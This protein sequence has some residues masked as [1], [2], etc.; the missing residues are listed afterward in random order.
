MQT[1][2]PFLQKQATLTRRSTV[3]SI[4]VQLGFPG[5]ADKFPLG[6]L[7]EKLTKIQSD[8]LKHKLVT[9]DLKVPILSIIF[10]FS[11]SIKRIQY[12]KLNLYLE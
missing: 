12:Q 1:L 5:G 11:L 7:G 2:F 6:D 10:T 4:P 9:G 8:C 3:L